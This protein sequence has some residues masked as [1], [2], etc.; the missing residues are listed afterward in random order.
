MASAMD[1]RLHELNTNFTNQ[2]LYN[3][4][5]LFIRQSP[6]YFVV[7]GDAIW[8]FRDVLVVCKNGNPKDH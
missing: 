2:E 4:M 5:D 7:C 6:N 1:L 3:E 8:S